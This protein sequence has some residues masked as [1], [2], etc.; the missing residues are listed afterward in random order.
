MNIKKHFTAEDSADSAIFEEHVDLKA[1]SP[2][3]KANLMRDKVNQ[4]PSAMLKNKEFTMTFANS[5]DASDF[6]VKKQRAARSIF[7]SGST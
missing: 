4:S 2:V 1:M 3:Q 7:V 6:V 5:R